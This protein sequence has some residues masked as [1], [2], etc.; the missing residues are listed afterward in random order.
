MTEKKASQIKAG[1][2]KSRD[3]VA[4]KN[5]YLQWKMKWR[6]KAVYDGQ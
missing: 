5:V 1:V 6:T 3:N 2:V 4:C